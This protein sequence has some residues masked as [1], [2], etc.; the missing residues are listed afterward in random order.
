MGEKI[1][2]SLIGSNPSP[3]IQPQKFLGLNFNPL[4][5]EGEPEH[6]QDH[7]QSTPDPEN[8]K[9][10]P[11]NPRMDEEELQDD[12]RLFPGGAAL[13]A[14]L[15]SFPAVYLSLALSSLL[16]LGLS[17]LA[18]ARVSSISSKLHQES[19]EWNFSSWDSFPVPDVPHAERALLDRAHRP[20]FRGKLGMGR[21]HR[22][23]I[24][25]HVLA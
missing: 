16:L 23:Q 6:S 3:K 5:G 18:L 1:W 13:P 20:E 7:S 4:E 2:I 25:L 10:P 24:L 21:R 8:Q 11:K 19:P 9:N 17:A 22:L 14:R 15:R 12:L